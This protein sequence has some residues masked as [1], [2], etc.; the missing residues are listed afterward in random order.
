MKITKFLIIPILLAFFLLNSSQ[1]INA[2]EPNPQPFVKQKPAFSV[3]GL[4]SEYYFEKPIP[5]QQEENYSEEAKKTVFKG[6]FDWDTFNN[7]LGSMGTA[8]AGLPPELQEKIAYHNSGAIGSASMLVGNLIDNRPI[9]TVEYIADLGSPLGIKPAYAQEG[10]TGQQRLAPVLP[11]WKAFRNVSYM[12]FVLIFV[13]VGF[14]IMF[15]AK[16]NP[17]TVISI[18]SAIPNLIITLIVITFSYAIASLMMDLIYV[19]MYLG[20]NILSTNEIIGTGD[21]YNNI[22]DTFLNGNVI[23]IGTGGALF[24]TNTGDQKSVIGGSAEAIGTLTSDIIWGN[25]SGVKGAVTEF[26]TGN[27]VYLIVAVAILF[28]LFKLFFQL[29][30]CYIGII[31]SVIF[32]P[33]QL[34]TNAFPGSNSLVNWLKGLLANIL[35]FPAIVLLFL[36]AGALT[37]NE[38]WGA[39]PGV[40]FT[41]FDSGTGLPLLGTTSTDAIQALIGLGMIMLAPKVVSMIKEALK[42]EKGSGIGAGIVAPMVGAV[43]MPMQGVQQAVT[44]G[45]ARQYLPGLL[46]KKEMGG[47]YSPTV[48]EQQK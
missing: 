28:S 7:L 34:L 36:I 18:E 45:Q 17:Q 39:G 14:M 6:T 43:N 35:P 16:I 15:R 23:N 44:I 38:K 25:S 5:L 29:L 33:F 2:Q 26:I 13:G 47:P 10:Q 31:M 3:L 12:V 40:G 32:A 21:G 46:G 9:S 48:G 41:G 30:M 20:I 19:I 8:V 11:I 4:E 37:G 27:L 1:I 22:M 42:V 24:G